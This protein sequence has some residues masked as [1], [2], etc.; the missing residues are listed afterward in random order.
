MNILDRYILK[1]IT[2]ASFL[3]LGVLIALTGFVVFLGELD[4]VGKG[5]FGVWNAVSYSLLMLPTQTF[6]MM[7]VAALKSAAN[8]RS[9][10][11]SDQVKIRSSLSSA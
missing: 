11:Y 3:V 7:P 4:D 2:G 5:S 8:L 10:M 9:S 6:D 1:A